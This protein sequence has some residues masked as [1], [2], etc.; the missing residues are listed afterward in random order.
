MVIAR[1]EEN[2]RTKKN[3]PL[4]LQLVDMLELEIRNSMSPNDKLLSERELSTTYDVSRITVRQAL[5]ELESRGLIYKKQGKGTYVSEIKGPTTDLAS[6]YSFT[7]HMKELEDEL[8]KLRIENAFLKEL[9]RLRLED[10]AKMRE[11]QKS[12]AVSEDSSN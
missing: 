8:L 7:E 3:Q 1:K 11:R 2:V 9:R 6:A 10:E 5:K 4:Y 12:S